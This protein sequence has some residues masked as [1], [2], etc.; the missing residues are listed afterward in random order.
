MNNYIQWIIKKSKGQATVWVLELDEVEWKIYKK[1]RRKKE[2]LSVFY[3]FLYHLSN[4]DK[5]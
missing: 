4:H 5:T 1:I 2:C 3:A